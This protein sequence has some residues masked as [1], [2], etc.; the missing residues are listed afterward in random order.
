MLRK[1]PL[2]FPLRSSTQYP[3]TSYLP[4]GHDNTK[5]GPLVCTIPEQAFFRTLYTKTRHMLILSG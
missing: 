2:F 4:L 1:H 5:D 3:F